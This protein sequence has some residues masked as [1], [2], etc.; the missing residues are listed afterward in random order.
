MQILLE[1]LM[2]PLVGLV[3]SYGGS[4]GCILLEQL[5]DRLVALRKEEW[6]WTAG[7]WS[8]TGQSAGRT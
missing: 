1:M 3:G 4:Y 5:G 8:T 2:E 6:A 7:S